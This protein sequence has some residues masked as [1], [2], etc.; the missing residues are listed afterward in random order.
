VKEESTKLVP[1]LAAG[2]LAAGLLAAACASAPAAPHP[3]IATVETFRAARADGDLERARSLLTDDPRLWF[4]ERTGA[5][6]AWTL[7]GG[8]WKSWDEHFN[9]VSERVTDW[10]VEPDR[11]W[12]D[13]LETNDYF[14]LLERGGSHWRATYFFAED[15]RIAGF[16]VSPAEG[17]PETAA[18]RGDEFRAWA[19]EHH[20]EE[21]EYLMPGG[22]IDP[23]AD[24]PERMRALLLAWRA[25][26]AE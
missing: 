10:H 13:M 16:T 8:R 6:S 17:R 22:S 26:L 2:L 3:W 20:P 21:A 4:D 14:E 12:A 25:S 24:R 18:G 7:D 1:P 23:T 11:V 19:F 9:G 15:G 5:G